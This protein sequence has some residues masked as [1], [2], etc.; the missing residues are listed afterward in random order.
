MPLTPAQICTLAL[1]RAGEKQ[2]VDDLGDDTVEAEIANGMYEHARDVVLEER[3]W[4]FAKRRAVLGVLASSESD[5][6]ARTGWAFTYAVP[7]DCIK[8]RYIETGIKNPAPDQQPAFEL[9]DDEEEGRILLTDYEDAELVYTYRVT[10][11]GKFTP[12]FTDA[13]IWRLAYEFTF[14]IPVKPG[15]GE[16][17][18][19]AYE[20]ALSKAAASD[21]N[22]QTPSKPARPSA[23]RA[24]TGLGASEE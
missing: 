3:Y 15:A 4:S 6:E 11:T 7:D 5:T 21:Y 14:A 17:M 1:R 8:P 9:E 23:V 18:M 10:L 2:A 13:L 24:R 20:M 22:S 12:L 19:G 16:R